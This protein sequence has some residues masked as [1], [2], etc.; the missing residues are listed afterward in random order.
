MAFGP[1]LEV[2]PGT[3]EGA[4]VGVLDILRTELKC[5]SRERVIGPRTGRGVTGCVL[6]LLSLLS[7]SRLY[8][9]S[10]AL[11]KH[12]T[13]RTSP[14]KCRLCIY[15]SLQWR[16]TI[17]AGRLHMANFGISIPA[18]NYPHSDW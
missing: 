12:R 17:V 3:E 2:G 15:S 9:S 11:K 1:G 7:L 14:R 13:T 5:G 10:C 8:V 18:S 6:F 16:F 4:V